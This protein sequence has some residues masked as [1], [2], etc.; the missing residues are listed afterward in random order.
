MA[1]AHGGGAATITRPGLSPVTFPQLGESVV[2]G[3]VLQ[4]LVKIGDTVEEDQLLTEIETEKV[5]AEIPSPFKG[6]VKEFAVEIGQTVPVGTT[7]LWIETDKAAADAAAQS[8]S[9]TQPAEQPTRDTPA[10]DQFAADLENTQPQPSAPQQ[11][12]QPA[13]QASGTNGAKEQAASGDMS[14]M[15]S[16]AVRKLAMEYGID[17][18]TVKG[19]GAGGRVTR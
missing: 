12:P 18:A 3:T 10:M 15:Y 16:P 7:L 1:E 17:P 2:E 4:W 19:T 6:V 8:P 14:R 11:S 5:V 13:Q 9:P